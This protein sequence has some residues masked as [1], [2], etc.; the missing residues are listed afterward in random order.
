VQAVNVIS[1]H[2]FIPGV[3]RPESGP[4]SSEYATLEQPY[5]DV[6]AQL[7]SAAEAI[8]GTTGT[9]DDVLRLRNDVLKALDM[10]WPSTI[11]IEELL[12][13]G[14]RLIRPMI[15]AGSM[16]EAKPLSDRLGR[17]IIQ[18]R[19]VG[20]GGPR[21]HFGASEARDSMQCIAE[22]DA[23]L[24]LLEMETETK[25]D[26]VP[27]PAPETPPKKRGFWRR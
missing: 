17:E 6:L 21:R 11:W 5:R 19:W 3:V 22:I 8:Q 1:G 13:I 27:M 7:S 9:F 23:D 4:T 20:D 15:A 12:V 25:P 2:E 10:D 16:V 18:R 26:G 24:R 14:H